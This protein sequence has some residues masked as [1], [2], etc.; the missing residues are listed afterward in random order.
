[1]AN[2]E[3]IHDLGDMPYRIARPILMQC[4]PDQLLEIERNSPVSPFTLAKNSYLLNDYPSASEG[5]RSRFV[6]P[7]VIPMTSHTDPQQM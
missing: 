3:T 2:I 4:Q 5:R 1:M 7:E 6:A